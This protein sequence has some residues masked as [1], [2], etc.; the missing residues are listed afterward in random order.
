MER[1][2]AGRRLAAVHARDDPIVFAEVTA[3]TF[4]RRLRGRRVVGSGRYGKHFWLELDE[5]PW[6]VMHLGM[7]GTIEVYDREADRPKFWKAEYVTDSGT[8]VAVTNKR[9]LG[10]LRL[11]DDP[12]NQRPISELGFDPLLD[13]PTARKIG[14]QLGRRSSPI[15]AVL[16][17]QGFAAGVGNW[18]ADEV[19][20]QAR[21]A[22][23]L[24]ADEL[25]AEQVRQL[26]Q[27]L[28]SVVR[29]A[30]EVDADARRFPR[31]WLFHHRWGRNAQAR[32]ARGERVIHQTIAGRTTAWAPQRQT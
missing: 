21:I 24:R 25:T 3:R 28:R 15:K 9:R 30:V 8:R 5:R 11:R 18:V 20:Y 22:P 26:R 10:R 4:A 13:L 23:R 17:D 14:E 19:L 12:R 27:K 6:P 32:T 31:T 16:L 29:K 7:T 1:A 2:L